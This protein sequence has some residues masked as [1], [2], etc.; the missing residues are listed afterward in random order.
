MVVVVFKGIC[1]LN[2]D[3][4]TWEVHFNH[5]CMVLQH[6]KDVN[7]KLNANKCMF[8]AKNIKFLGHVVG[9]IRTKPNL[10]KIRF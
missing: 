1:N 7:L 2:I 10:E 6:L 8:C 4:V 5:I 3:N 9:K